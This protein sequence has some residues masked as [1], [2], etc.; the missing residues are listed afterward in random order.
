VPHLEHLDNLYD[1]LISGYYE[2]VIPQAYMKY[3]DRPESKDRLRVAL[4]SVNEMHHYKVNGP[5]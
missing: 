1:I 2:A 4:V 3:E 5:Q